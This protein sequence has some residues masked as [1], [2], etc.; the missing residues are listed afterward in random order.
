MSGLKAIIILLGLQH[1]LVFAFSDI[2]E[3]DNKRD[4]A[5]ILYIN[6]DQ[7]QQHTLH[8]LTDQDWFKFYANEL[9]TY[10]ISLKHGADIDPIIQI[11][12]ETSLIEEKK[13]GDW[14]APSQGFYYFKVIDQNTKEMPCRKEIQYELE[15]NTG[16]KPTFYGQIQGY[17]RDAIYGDSVEDVVISNSCRRNYFVPSDKNGHYILPSNKGNC[18]LIAEKEAYKPI[19]CNVEIPELTPIQVNLALLPIDQKIPTPFT[20]KQTY[21]RGERLHVEIDSKLLSPQTCVRYYFGIGYPNGR[22]FIIADKNKLELLNPNAPIAWISN[23]NILIDMPINETMPNGE[24]KLY[25]LRS[26]ETIEQALK[27]IHKGEWNV[28]TFKIN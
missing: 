15:I 26:A 14:N 21:H 27:N 13:Q 20:F 1:Q 18:E 17:I 23:D 28:G 3:P 11:Y 4:Q 10:E 7:R 5:N 16:G 8:S 22:L 2:Y 9:D 12:N 19:I 24:Y 25:I 6:N